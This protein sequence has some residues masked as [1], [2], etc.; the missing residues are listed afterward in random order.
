MYLKTAN[1][2]RFLLPFV[3]LEGGFQTQRKTAR[4]LECKLVQLLGKIEYES[5][6]T[7]SVMSD[8]SPLECSPPGSSVH[9]ILQARI[10]QWVAIPFSRDLPNPEIEPRS[11]EL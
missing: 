7:H 9:E 2:H 4:G 3:H 6:V 5:E 10:L 11:P 1:F 8:C